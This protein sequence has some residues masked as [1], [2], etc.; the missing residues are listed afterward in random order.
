MLLVEYSIETGVLISASM[1]GVSIPELPETSA[2]CIIKDEDK[3]RV[4]WYSHVNGGTVIITVNAKGEFLS[5]EIE[6][7]TPPAPEPPK[8][9][10]QERIEQLEAESADLWYDTMLKD[11]RISEHD[12]DIADIWYTIMTG[13]VGA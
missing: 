4:I 7:V 6:V 5:A 9:P 2:S 13:G 11:A 1:G 12:T 8:S 10:E 3:A